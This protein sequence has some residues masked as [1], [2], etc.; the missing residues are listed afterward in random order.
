MITLLLA[1]HASFSVLM[2]PVAAVLLIAIVLRRRGRQAK[3][4]E[5]F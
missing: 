2:W 3:K 1:T 5:R 4:P